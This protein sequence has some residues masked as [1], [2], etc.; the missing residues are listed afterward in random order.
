M[1]RPHI[2][3]SYDKDEMY[4]ILNCPS[5]ADESSRTGQSTVAGRQRSTQPGG[6]KRT[7]PAPGSHPPPLKPRSQSTA[8]QSSSQPA[9]AS[10]SELCRRGCLVRWPLFL[11]VLTR[12]LRLLCPCSRG[13]RLTCR[14]CCPTRVWGS[15]RS[16]RHQEAGLRCRASGG[17]PWEVSKHPP[18]MVKR[19]QKHVTLSDL[20]F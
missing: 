17:S 5:G 18:T 15:S 19:V 13:A 9:A 10:K 6:A 1:R 16:I 12:L 2:G 11:D 3:F 4:D 7:S 8:S 14:A 20:T